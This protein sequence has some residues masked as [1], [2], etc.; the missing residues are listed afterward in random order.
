DALLG[1]PETDW[2]AEYLA[3]Y[4]R[5]RERGERRAAELEAERAEG[6][7]PSLAAS[8]YAGL[9][10]DSLYGEVRVEAGPYGLVLRYSPDYVADLEHW[11][12]DT[13]RAVWRRDG[14]GRAFV[15][16]TLDPR[17][18]P[19]DLELQGFTTFRRVSEPA[20]AASR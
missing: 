7:G 14:F 12:H 20:A 6:T 11:H 8:D 4:E 5:S 10:A 15:T 16:F 3:L 9:Y 19:R 1:V 18:R 17:G 13:F 2:S